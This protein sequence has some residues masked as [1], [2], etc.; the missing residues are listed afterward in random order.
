MEIKKL[1]SV[2]SYLYDLDSDSYTINSSEGLKIGY[3]GWSTSSGDV[4][5]MISLIK[6]PKTP[7]EKNINLFLS[8]T[9]KNAAVKWVS[10]APVSY[11]GSFSSDYS[12]PF[13]ELIKKT[14][15]RQVQLLKHVL[16]ISRRYAE[17]L[18]ITA[19][20]HLAILFFRMLT[21]PIPYSKISQLSTLDSLDDIVN[22]LVGEST[23]LSTLT[24][25]EK[26]YL[27]GKDLNLAEEFPWLYEH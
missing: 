25:T 21:D 13:T 22:E 9:D 6:N 15:D 26:R 27:P 12:V 23:L 3:L 8:K 10:A 1:I 24:S 17:S 16:V 20:N 14:A 19:P 5:K 7:V 2:Y 11:T 18:G 4:Q